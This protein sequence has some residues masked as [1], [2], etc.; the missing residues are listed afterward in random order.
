MIGEIGAAVAGAYLVDQ[1][2]SRNE[3]S[4]AGNQT[5]IEKLTGQWLQDLE[6]RGAEYKPL[7]LAAEERNGI[8]AFLLV[9]LAWQESRFRKDIVTGATVSG[10]GAVGIMQIVPRWHP[11]MTISDCQTPA[12]A[13]P[14]A[15]GYLRALYR[16]F[17]SWELALKAYNWGPGNVNKWLARGRIGEPVETARYSAEILSDWSDATGRNLA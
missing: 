15:A 6:T 17:N 9:R 4:A 10:A 7:L 5:M 12:I 1:Y 14:Y 3:R 11:S 16:Q 2:L 8:P 13:I